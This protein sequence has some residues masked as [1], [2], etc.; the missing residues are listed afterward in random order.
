APAL[1]AFEG[2]LGEPPTRL[3]YSF[4]PVPTITEVCK[5][6]ILG[7]VLPDACHGDLP[8]TL[9]RRYGLTSEQLQ[10]AAHWQDAERVR[11]SR[12]VRLLVYRDNRLDEH[13]GTLTSY[14]TLRES[15]DS[16]I[17]SVARLV[18]RWAEEFRHWHGSPPLVV[19]TG[20]HGFTYGPK[21]GQETA[22]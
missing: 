3:R 19:L 10:L 12:P 11:V 14:R 1:A 6:A 13:L 8:G 7:G 21:G 2:Q 9:R 4:S 22:A 16:I 20:D 5:E 17:T 18:S 15:F